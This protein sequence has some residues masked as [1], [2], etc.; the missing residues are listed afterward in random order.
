MEIG[1]RNNVEKD[2]LTQ[3]IVRFINRDLKINDLSEN[4]LFYI[5]V[6]LT[7]KE[8]DNLPV[9]LKRKIIIVKHV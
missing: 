9:S 6:D 2:I 1:F 7:E 5:N 3:Y 8:L 4:G